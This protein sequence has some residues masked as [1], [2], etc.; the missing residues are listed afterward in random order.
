MC[1]AHR[2]FLFFEISTN[3]NTHDS[4]AFASSELGRWLAAGR[5]E[6]PGYGP[7]FLNGDNAYPSCRYIVVPTGKRAHAVFDY[8]QSSVRMPIECSFGI[9][10]RRWGIFWRP[11]EMKFEMRAATI[12]ACMRLH[13]YCIDERLASTNHPSLDIGNVVNGEAVMGTEKNWLPVP[14]FGRNGRPERLMSGAGPDAVAAASAA[15]SSLRGRSDVRANLVAQIDASQRAQYL[16][17]ARR[18]NR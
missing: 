17:A 9:L 7:F 6:H 10:V 8:V 11:L 15:W 2:R 14:L 5:L 13:N 12:S 18:S 16:F 4:S 1:D 3:P